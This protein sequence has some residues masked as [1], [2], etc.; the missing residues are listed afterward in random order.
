MGSDQVLT[1]ADVYLVLY[2]RLAELVQ[3]FPLP[4]MTDEQAELPSVP[5]P[6][7]LDV[8]LAGDGLTTEGSSASPY[9]TFVFRETG[10]TPAPGLKN[11]YNPNMTLIKLFW[12][13]PSLAVHETLFKG[14]DGHRAYDEEGLPIDDRDILHAKRHFVHRKEIDLDEEQFV[15][16]DWDE[17]VAISDVN[18]H[19]PVGA[20]PSPVLPWNADPQWAM[21]WSPVYALVVTGLATVA[22]QREEEGPQFTLK[23]LIKHAE[24]D[25][26][27]TF[28]EFQ[29][30]E[31]M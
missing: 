30:S 15:V 27:G 8:P 7:I 12:A 25:L 26:S 14:P 20:F 24:N 9:W 6:F 21:N 28:A 11:H 22:T 29:T 5:N 1:K 3:V 2:S 10:H 18:H 4:I 23:D 19:Q 17:S 16:D 31:T 13:D